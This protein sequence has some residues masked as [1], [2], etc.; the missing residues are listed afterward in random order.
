MFFLSGAAALIYQISW[1]RQIGLLFGNTVNAAAVVLAS[2]FSG[3]SLGYFI[4]GKWSSRANP[5]LGYAVAELTV[6]A[7]ASLFPALLDTVSSPLLRA[8]QRTD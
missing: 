8:L 7:W 4:G 3:M 6:A 2:Y 1:S 5:L